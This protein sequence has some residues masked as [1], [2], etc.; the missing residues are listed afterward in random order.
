VCVSVCELYV[1]L[2]GSC[3]IDS[4]GLIGRCDIDSGGLKVCECV[5]ECVCESVEGC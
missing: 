5:C 4:G 1:G 3:D 2:V